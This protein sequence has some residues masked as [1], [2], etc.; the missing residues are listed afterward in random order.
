[1]SSNT[2]RRWV[3]PLVGALLVVTVVAGSMVLLLNRDSVARVTIGEPSA[4]TGI[5]PVEGMSPRDNPAV[6]PI[7]TDRLFVYGGSAP[8]PEAPGSVLLDDAYVLDLAASTGTVT[9]D[10]PLGT[11]RNPSAASHGS[12]VVVLGSACEDMTARGENGA[13]GCN[14]GRYRAAVFDV[15]RR[16]WRS[17]ALPGA[18]SESYGAFSPDTRRVNTLVS[19]PFASIAVFQVGDSD[20]PALLSY[21]F[22][23]Q[24]WA[25]LPAVDAAIGYCTTTNDDLIALTTSYENLGQV[26]PSLPRPSLGGSVSGSMSDGYVLPRLWRYDKAHTTWTPGPALP[27]VK[28]LAIQEGPR[29]GCMDDGAAIFGPLPGDA[30]A[31]YDVASASWSTPVVPPAPF[32]KGSIIWTGMEIEALTSAIQGNFAVAAFNPAAGEFRVSQ[33]PLVTTN[34]IWNGSAAV[35]YSGPTSVLRVPEPGSPLPRVSTTAVGAGVFQ[36]QP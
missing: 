2:H 32:G 23:R 5:S 18:L 3:L 34:A 11:L 21:D 12:E 22:D 9:S 33:K 35:G 26:V 15:D 4:A 10:P 24:E 36:V 13:F 6:A 8:T 7:G 27:D 31:S 30:F 25:V 20:R 14:D 1:M 28:Y 29:L 17:T 16:E 19:R